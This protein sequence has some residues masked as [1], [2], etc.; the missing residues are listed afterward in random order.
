MNPSAFIPFCQ[1]GGKMFG[2]KISHFSERVCSGFKPKLFEGEICFSLDIN[3]INDRPPIKQGRKFGLRLLLDYNEESS[4]RPSLELSPGSN[5]VGKATM[6]QAKPHVV[7]EDH[8]TFDKNEM[9]GL[10]PH[11]VSTSSTAK[12]IK[13]H[14]NTLKPYTASGG[15]Q[16]LMTAVK[17]MATTSG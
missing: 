4:T 8:I 3:K 7:N 16:Y 6:E 13:V 1:F 12:M 14:I 9:V 15:G 10:F 2:K 17:E 5:N 11:L